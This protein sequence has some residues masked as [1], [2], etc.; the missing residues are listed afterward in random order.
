FSLQSGDYTGQLQEGTREGASDKAVARELQSMGLVPVYV[1]LSPDGGSAGGQSRLAQWLAGSN[2]SAKQASWL[3][4]SGRRVT[5]RD[6]LLFTQELATLLNAGVPLDRALSICSELT[7]S[8]V[9]REVVADVLRQVRSGR[10]LADALEAQ[11]KV[12]SKL[13]INM[14]RAGQ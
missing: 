14:V 5:A 3:S 2:D 10:S 11:G 12:F 6:R 13:Y 1:G 7:E 8:K 9:F 4:F